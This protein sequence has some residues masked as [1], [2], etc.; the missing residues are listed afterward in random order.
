MDPVEPVLKVVGLTALDRAELAKSLNEGEIQFDRERIGASGAF[1]DPAVLEATI[2]LTQ[3]SLLVFGAW[4]QKRR[5][6][7]RLNMEFRAIDASGA[8]RE[9][10]VTFDSSS[11]EAAPA[12]VLSQ[13][14]HLANL[15]PPQ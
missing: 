1:G 13:I 11:A 12:N 5:S 3:T 7:T 6:K 4:L 9:L 15:S 2:A 8:R 10:D 14:A